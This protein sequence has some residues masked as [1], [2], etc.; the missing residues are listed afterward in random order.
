MRTGR[1]STYREFWPYYVSQHLHPLNRAL[2]AVGTTF[3][4]AIAAGAVLT[5]PVWMFAAPVAGY[6][7]AWL[8]HLVFE[9]NRPATFRHPVWSLMGDFHM[10]GLML[11]GQM[12]PE[13][14]YARRMYPETA[15]AF[16]ARGA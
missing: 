3:V 4:I 13:L 15:A 2:H 11:L 1:P 6:S 8:G 5:T 7:F 14:E 16:D 9:R 12:K 10:Y